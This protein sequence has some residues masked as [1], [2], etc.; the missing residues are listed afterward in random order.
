M[1]SAEA[2]AEL[3]RLF[4]VRKDPNRPIEVRRRE[5]EADSRLVVLPKDARFS[6]VTIGE[7]SAEWMETPR[8]A[9]DRVFLFLHGGGYN[10]GSPRTHRRLAACLSRA[11]HMRVLTPDYRLAPEHPFPAGVRDALTVYGWLL[12]QGIGEENIVVGGDSAGGG[13]TLS[14]LLALREAGAKMPLAGV[15]M[16]PWTDLTVS[17][18]SYRSN[19]KFDPI[20]TQEGLREAGLWYAGQ[21]NPAD[22]MMSPLF[23]D[24][25]GLPPL[26]I[27]AASDEVMVDDSRL[28]ADRAREHG[29]EVSCKVFDGLWHCFQHAGTEI[30]ESRQ[31]IDEIGAYVRALH[32]E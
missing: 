9:R 19:R 20:I 31:A 17:S 7:L 5:W 2:K 27:Q 13:L 21:R 18:P 11:T 29:V 8:V 22:P 25:S 15:L 16:A 28:L 3:E 24:L 14:M 10:A 12:Q 30:P 23:A 1:A 32:V 6:R 26:L 4:A